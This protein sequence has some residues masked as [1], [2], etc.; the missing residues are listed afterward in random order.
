MKRFPPDHRAFISSRIRAKKI[1]MRQI[2]LQWGH[3]ENYVARALADPDP[4]IGLLLQLSDTLRENLLEPYVKSLDP[5]LR[6]TA[7]ERQLQQQLSDTQ[8]QLM[9]I[10]E[11]RD[12]YWEALKNKG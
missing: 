3:A 11:E 12:R 6:P 1:S 7:A 4:R 2:S 8:L 10:T 5:T 9:R